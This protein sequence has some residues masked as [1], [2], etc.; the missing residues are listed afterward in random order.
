M[1]KSSFAL[2][3]TLAQASLAVAGNVGDS[4]IWVTD[5]KGAI[6][7]GWVVSFP[8]G[9]SDFFSV[10]HNVVP[11]LGNSEDVVDG[12]PVTGIALSVNDFGSTSTFPMVG[13]FYSNFVLDP[14]GMTPDLQQPISTVT[15]PVTGTPPLFAFVPIDLPEV[16]IAPGTSIVNAVVQEPPGDSGLLSIGGD[17]TDHASGNST[18]SQDGYATPAIVFTFIDWGLNPGQDNLSTTSCTPADRLPNGRLRVSGL[19][20]TE[21]GA[22]DHLTTTVSA[23]SSVMLSFFGNQSGDQLRIMANASD[24]GTV[25]AI[26][27]VLSALP[28]P[29]GDGSYLRLTAVWPRG[30]GGSTFQFSALWGNNSCPLPGVGFTNCVTVIVAPDPIFGILDDGTI[31][32][33]WVVQI[34]SGSSD[35]FNN[36]FGLVPSTVNNVLGIGVSVFDFV[37]A[38]PAY[39]QVGISDANLAIDPTGHTPDLYG[40]GLLSVIA[41]FTFPSGSIET[42]SG[43]YTS[44][45]CPLPV[46][47]SSFVSHAHGWVQ[48]PPGDPG[49]VGVGADSTNVTSHDSFYTLDGYS[50]PAVS[51]SVIW[52]IRLATN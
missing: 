28:D 37:T 30:Y 41:P 27:P 40:P 39:P 49:L 45:T 19:P 24:C 51:F 9:S 22:G 4:T 16:A 52:G 14:S 3:L 42:T 20:S 44:H 25:T 32:N 36:D 34:P 18:W 48:L 47:A 2:G 33:G 6:D 46:P 8:T 10:A 29:D 35:Y 31:E 5:L 12:L 15:N 17:D 13:V 7:S 21:V 1:R 26:G 43:Q 50:S 11:G 23:D 38:V